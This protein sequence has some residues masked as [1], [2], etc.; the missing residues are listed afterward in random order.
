MSDNSDNNNTNNTDTPKGD[1]ENPML[2]NHAYPS[3]TDP[4]FQSIMYAKREFYANAIPH[5]PTFTNYSELKEYRDNRCARSYKLNEHQ[6]LLSNFINPDTPYHGVLIF[7]GTG[8]GKT[9]ASIAIAEKFKPMVEKYGTKIHVLVPGPMNKENFR[10]EILSCSGESYMKI[11]NEDGLVMTEADKL[12]LRKNAVNLVA[13]Y[14]RIMSYRSFYKKVLGEKIAETRTNKDNKLKVR[15]RKNEEGDFERD[16]SVDRIYNLNNGIIIVD[17]A[18]NLTEN[19]YGKALRKIIQNSVNLKVVLLTATPM[20]NLADD[21]IQLINFIRPPNA[22]MER[23]KIFNS[24]MDYAMDF[25]PTGVEY[26]KKMCRGY[27]SYLR[28]AD[29]LTYAQR[30]DMGEIP[31]GLLFTKVI[32]CEMLPFQLQTYINAVKEGEGDTLARRSQAVANFAFPGLSQDRKDLTGYYG[33]EGISVLRNQVKSYSDQLN[34]KIAQVLGLQDSDYVYL[35]NN[36]KLISGS[37]MKL[38][39]LK[40]FSI[41]F[42]TAMTNINQLVYGMKGPGTGFVYSNLVKA[43]IELFQEIAI[44]NGYLEYQESKENYQIKK[45]TICYYCGY[46]FSEHDK[47]IRDAVNGMPKHTFYPAT[48]ITITGKSEETVEMVP[49]EKQKLLDTFN[50]I[51]NKDGKHIKLIFGSKVMNEGLTL[52]NV[53]EVHILDVHF[54][55]GRVDQVIG[56]AIRWC[57]H[58][59]VMSEQNPYPTV[60]IYKYVVMLQG[61]LSSEE[62]MYKKAELKY[63]LVKKVERAMKEVAIDCPLN[64]NGNVFPE[65][66]AKYKD[67]GPKD[68]PCPAICD[69]MQ[70]D[71][72]CDDELL[73]AKYYDPERKIYKKISKDKLDY[74]TFTNALAREEIE[75]SKSKIKE[76]YK[77]RHVY[78][79]DD[80]LR[81]VKES[82]PEDRRDLF[83]DFFVFQALNELIPVSENDFNNFKDTILDKFNTG[84]YLIYRK[85]YY[86]YQPFAENEYLPMYYRSNHEVNVTNQLSLHTYLRHL[87]DYRKHEQHEQ[88]ERNEFD[89]RSEEEENEGEYVTNRGYDFDSIHDYYDQRDEFKYVGS[90]D[91]EI[92]RRKNKTFEEMKDVFNIRER[93]PKVLKKKRETGVPSLKGAVCSTSKDKSVLL[94]IAKEVGVPMVQ[95]Q[96]STRINICDA[97]RD[98]LLALEKYSTSKLGN[99]MTYM[100]I[101]A[102]HPQYPFPYNLEDRVKSILNDIQHETRLKLIYKIHTI[103]LKNGEYPDIHYVQYEIEIDNNLDKFPHIITK[104]KI[105]KKSASKFIIMV[106]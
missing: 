35:V 10:K 99:K 64:R 57:T 21:I 76:M 50:N 75:Y 16:I 38:E 95:P 22:P 103:K 93:R 32:R 37:M 79:L 85:D 7:H 71:F 67:C 90:I 69:Y 52:K 20:K 87:D 60:Q 92:G 61:E 65:D 106:E 101:P 39:N 2:R 96:S 55:L 4:D 17:E 28:G 72:K 25:K 80:I 13:Q 19:E 44:Q 105:Q 58:Y 86:I 45:N 59:P 36:G 8:T 91:K 3:P 26:L 31:P 40:Y 34:K 89:T 66:L 78:K 62:E 98:K 46:K 102:N 9:C 100:I 53:K 73:N 5:R 47:V 48:F 82:Y 56:R 30:I 83:D 18:H 42:Y 15:Y 49:E 68:N 11:N 14:Y 23:D 29:P 33:K 74:S 63:L 6:T 1:N 41:K 24:Q 104:Y 12:R 43:G 94:R 27:I 88:H 54:N 77:L 84:G 70:C 97:I 51:D 81:Y